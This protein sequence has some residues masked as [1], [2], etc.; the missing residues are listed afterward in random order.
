LAPRTATI[1]S[2]Y[3]NRTGAAI[4]LMTLTVLSII[5]TTKFSFGGGEWVAGH[6]TP[7]RGLI[8]RWQDWRAA[9]RRDRER[10]QI[11]EKHVKRAGK[12]RAPEDCDKGRRRRRRAQEGR[13][14]NRA[15]AD[16]EEDEEAEA[17]A[18]RRAAI[19][20]PGPVPVPQP[21]PLSD[22]DAARESGRTPSGRLRP[23][24]AI[25]ARRP[26]DPH[27]IDEREL[28]DAARL[29][30]EK[31]REFSVEGSVVQIIPARS[32]RPTSSSRT[33]A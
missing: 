26:K 16:D 25:A 20:R 23:A 9:R 2:A 1:L 13:A 17:P 31:C 11:V 28:M 4:L 14:R 18:P 33:P 5:V 27:K 7:E 32:S 3:L 22:T 15:D 30:E 29:L 8:E 24:V 21:L 19:K 10:Q 6:L 12:E